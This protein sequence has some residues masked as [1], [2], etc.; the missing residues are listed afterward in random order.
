MTAPLADALPYGARD[1]KITEYLDAQGMVLGDTSVDLPFIQRLS[2]VE[3]EEFQDLRGDDKLITTRGRGSQVNWDLESGGLSTPAWAIFTGGEVIESGLSPNRRVE[4]RKKATQSRPFFRID[5]RI[6]SDSGG[7]IKVRI[8]RARC[9]SDIQTDFQDGEF[10][11]TQVSGVGLPLLDDAND[12]IYSIFRDETPTSLTLTPDPNPV[13]APLNLTVG[14]LGGTSPAATAALTW[15]AVP[16]ASGYKI[17]KSTD[18]EVTWAAGTPATSTVANVTETGLST[19]VVHFRVIAT[20]NGV[21]SEPSLSI[22]VTI[23]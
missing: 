17:E 22:A 20:V 14:A 16:G 21:D 19:G 1:I 11:T 4:L 9:T 7:D 13:P 2:F 5:A 23:P 3:A 8:Y 18:N 12:L 10:A 15:G 6:L